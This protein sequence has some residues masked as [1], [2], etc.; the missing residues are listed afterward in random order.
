MT[1]DTRAS[2]IFKTTLSILGIFVA[3]YLSFNYGQ[4]TN[5]REM[6]A[7]QRV[8]SYVQYIQATARRTKLLHEEGSKEDILEQEALRNAA[9][10]RATIYASK[11]VLNAWELVETVEHGSEEWRQA[12]ITWFQAMRSEIVSE[13]DRVPDKTIRT[14]LFLEKNEVQ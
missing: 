11:S 10:F 6:L 2:T 8:S 9:R 3:A 5:R 12:S 7:D 1:E 13:R 14:L 4:E